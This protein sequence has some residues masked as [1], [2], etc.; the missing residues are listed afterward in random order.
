MIFSIE[1]MKAGKS[2]S[3]IFQESLENTYDNRSFFVESLGYILEESKE[4]CTTMVQFNLN[5]SGFDVFKNLI[6]KIDPIKIIKN[7]FTWFCNILEKVFKEF[8]V[9]YIET[10]SKKN[11]ISRYK[12]KIESYN[13]E[14]IS[15]EARYIYTNLGSNTSYTTY[16]MEIEKE[17]TNLIGRLIEF[18]DWKTYESLYSTIDK[19]KDENDPDNVSKYL[20]YTMGKILGLRSSVEKENFPT[21]L[22]KYFR[23]NGNTIAQGAISPN[24]YHT[25]CSDHFNY[26]KDIKMIEKDKSDMVRYSKEIQNKITAIKLDDYIQKE[27][28]TDDAKKIFID[29]LKG[30]ANMVK[31]IC[32]IYL[33][34]FTVKIDAVKE[35]YLSDQKILVEVIKSIVR[36]E[37]GNEDGN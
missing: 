1:T 22:F 3:S 7:I 15:T 11:I 8:Q 9:L 16:K 34:V 4:F 13:K 25:M 21:E 5:E 29:M 26:K 17:Y 27:N 33:Q 10:C 20:S 31:S 19:I 28:I 2:S 36:E 37:G 24:E 32:D 30:K 35:K 12:S 23:N 18:R 6:K 14:V